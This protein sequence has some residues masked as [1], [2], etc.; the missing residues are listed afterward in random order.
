M[1]QVLQ[2]RRSS[3]AAES[4]N[5]E[6]AGGASS[7]QSEDDH[8]VAQ[9]DVHGLAPTGPK[10]QNHCPDD[11]G[12][13]SV[14]HLSLESE[15]L[16]IRALGLRGLRLPSLRHAAIRQL[17]DLGYFVDEDARLALRPESWFD[18]YVPVTKRG[19]LTT[20]ALDYLPHSTPP[21][22][23]STGSIDGAASSEG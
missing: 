17:R 5:P 12:R 22:G 15:G 13:G 18:A 9:A 19:L 3:K 10:T 2:G 7:G 4:R 8:Q 20:P 1:D 6:N 23:G 16:L 11:L 14:G 21:S